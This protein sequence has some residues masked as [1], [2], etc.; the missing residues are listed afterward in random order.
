VLYFEKCV[1]PEGNASADKFA[2][3]KGARP[4]VLGSDRKLRKMNA[5]KDGIVADLGLKLQQIIKQKSLI[6]SSNL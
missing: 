1:L 2:K 5:L 3:T 6:L 4:K